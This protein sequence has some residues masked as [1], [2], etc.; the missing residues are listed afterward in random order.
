M[1]FDTKN[2]SM[3]AV[4]ENRCAGCQECL[5]RCP[6]NAISMDTDNWV[7]VVDQS[8]CVGCGQCER[9]CPFSAIVV[10]TPAKVEPHELPKITYPEILVGST[11][12]VRHTFNSLEEA[13]FEASRCLNCPDPTCVRGCPAHN[14]IPEFIAALLNDDLE[15]ARKTIALT[16]CLPGANSRVC[17]WQSQCEGS[18][19]WSLRG[20]EGV[21]V[22]RLE[23]FIYDE[24]KDFTLQLPQTQ[25]PSITKPLSVAV[26]GSGPAGL[27]AAYELANAG[28]NVTVYEAASAP[29]GV[30]R[31]GIPSYVLPQD[32]W[33]PTVD[34]LENNGV[35]FIYNTR[36]E[37]DSI[38]SMLKDYG[39]VI[40]ATGAMAPILPKL[41]SIDNPNVLNA[42]E[43][44]DEAKAQLSTGRGSL[45]MV[46]RRVLV[47]G[48][49]NTAMDVARTS[50]RLGAS[51][52]CVDWVSE[53]FSK[54]RHDE[55]EEARHEGVEVLFNTTV[56][57]LQLD[58]DFI[59][60][61]VLKSTEQRDP[62]KLP[63]ILKNSDKKVLVDT[64]V[65]A[66]GYKVDPSWGSLKTSI[67]NTRA[68][69][70]PDRRWV[71]SGIFSGNSK[72]ATLALDRER[73]RVESATKIAPKIWAAGDFRT[74]PSTVVTAMAQGMSAARGVL[75]DYLKSQ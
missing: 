29:G 17:D 2:S 11:A 71:A 42:T 40:V 43:F 66:L 51:A 14:N 37:N 9:T 56:S 7:V 68:D 5:I 38:E 34:L 74:G 45:D 72:I 52:T 69:N 36:V 62:G 54:A 18:C 49:G 16:S 4:L 35:S 61:A 53:K 33:L 58:G 25:I 50:L 8:L 73:I 21:A 19:T 27:G 64:V 1:V 15:G 31:W 60:S 32:A 26:L 57:E 47:L 22:G 48:A 10:N 6:T 75:E 30:L 46:G 39:A 70:M 28:V 65:L 12:E 23:H 63:K 67:Q 24:T 41:N 59:K 44:L 3:V 55:I 13:K 20:E